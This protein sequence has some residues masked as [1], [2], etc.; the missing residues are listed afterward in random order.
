MKNS[1]TRLYSQANWARLR[2]AC[3]TRAAA[4]LQASA[5][6]RESTIEHWNEK[7]NVRVLGE[8]FRCLDAETPEAFTEAL[9]AL[10]ERS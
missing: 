9:D 10:R 7:V 5:S 4:H 8:V 3:K 6:M 1:D 2:D